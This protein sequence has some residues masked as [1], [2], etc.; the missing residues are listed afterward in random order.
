MKAYFNPKTGKFEFDG[1]L[2]EI[3]QL[4]QE[5]GVSPSVDPVE[6][7]AAQDLAGAQGNIIESSGLAEL[8]SNTIPSTNGRLDRMQAILQDFSGRTVR[9]QDIYG[10]YGVSDWTIREDMRVMGTRG[11]IQKV[12]RS[13]YRIPE[14]APPRQAPKKKKS[15]KKTKSPSNDYY[16]D[17]QSQDFR[18]KALLIALILIEHGISVCAKNSTPLLKKIAEKAGIRYWYLPVAAKYARRDGLVLFNDYGRRAII[19]GT[20]APAG[21]EKVKVL[22]GVHNLRVLI[23]GVLDQR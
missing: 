22:D 14:H 4:C 23:K 17:R 10:R 12:G 15:K 21:Y 11:I 18:D 9:L 16:F 19:Y 6:R 2:E 20:L 8:L 1:S 7:V 5:Q 3:R 13:R